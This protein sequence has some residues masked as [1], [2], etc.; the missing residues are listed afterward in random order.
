MADKKTVLVLFGGASPEHV[1]SCSSGA[2]LIEAIDTT[3]AFNISVFFA[4]LLLGIGYVIMLQTT[5][6]WTKELCPS[7]S[8]GQFEGI[9]CISYGLLPMIFGSLTSHLVIMKTGLTFK[10]YLEPAE[11]IPN[12]TIFV[13]GVIISTF[14]LMPLCFANKEHQKRLHKK[15]KTGNKN[16][17]KI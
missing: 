11:Y 13:A 3:K 15:E 17:K 6:A 10:G 4:I 8:K 12:G 1:V 7:D 2:S 9:W 14:C 16:K 5:K